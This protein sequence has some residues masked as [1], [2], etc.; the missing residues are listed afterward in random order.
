MARKPATATA[1]APAEKAAKPEVL[2]TTWLA[3]HVNEATG[4]EYDGYAIRILLRQLVKDEVIERGDGRYSFSGP[5][6]KTVVAVVKAVKDGS[7]EKAKAERLAKLKADKAAKTDEAPKP[8]GRSRRAKA[9]EADEE[10]EVKPAAKR[11]RAKA[12]PAPEPEAADD[13]LDIDEI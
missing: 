3:D 9:A 12:K 1:E 6:D 11:S 8:T 13:D 2:G 5:K 7:A 4:S 10:P